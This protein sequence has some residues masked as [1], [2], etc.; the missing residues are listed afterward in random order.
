MFQ[1]DVVVYLL[2]SDVG[3]VNNVASLLGI[4]VGLC[5][6]SSRVASVAELFLAQDSM[7]RRRSVKHL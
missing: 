7:A 1:L 2:G 5:F 6:D 4:P 3:R